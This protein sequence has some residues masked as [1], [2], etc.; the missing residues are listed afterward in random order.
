MAAVVAVWQRGCRRRRH[1]GWEDGRSAQRPKFK[2]PKNC[3]D[4]N[5]SCWSC[6]PSGCHFVLVTMPNAPGMLS[7]GDTDGERAAN[8][9]PAYR[10]WSQALAARDL[11]AVRESVG[12]LSEAVSTWVASPNIPRP[13]VLRA[14]WARTCTTPCG[15]GGSMSR[16]PGNSATSMVQG[17]TSGG[18]RRSS[19]S[20]RIASRALKRSHASSVRLRS[21]SRRSRCRL[22]CGAMIEQE[23]R[24]R[25]ARRRL[26]R[27]PPCFRHLVDCGCHREHRQRIGRCDVTPVRCA[28]G[29]GLAGDARPRRV[30]AS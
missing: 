22:A 2:T 9:L 6:I 29:V 23:A 18:V 10:R 7:L 17:S 13:E 14:F 21:V 20:Q 15:A 3:R 26:R 24:S 12:A 28:R 5:R 4:A 27:V 25:L 8:W 30:P 19:P 11:L 16:F 1:R